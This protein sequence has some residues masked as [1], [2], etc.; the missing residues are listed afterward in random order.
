MAEKKIDPGT[1]AI[2]LGALDNIAREM[3][4]SME[5]SAWSFIINTIRDFSTCIVDSK[6]NLLAV[7]EE[8]LPCQAMSVQRLVRS[9]WNHFKGEVYDGDILM[10]NLAYLGNTHMGEPTVA[11]PVFYKGE[12][13]FFVTARGHMM[14]MGSHDP[15]SNCPYAKDIYY[16]GLKIPPTKLYNRGKLNQEFLDLF[17]TNTRYRAW[18]HG[19]LMAN[20]AAVEVGKE[21]LIK[22]VDQYGPETV[23]FY[24]EEI[25][26]Y[27]E[28]MVREEIRKMKPGTYYAEDWLDTNAYGY[29]N[30]PV[31]AKLTIKD[32]KWIV[33]LSDNV[34]Q[35]LGAVNATLEGCTEAAVAGSLAFSI[36]P[37]IP[38]NEGIH[39][40]IQIICPPGTILSAT[41]PYSTQAATTAAADLLY[42]VL[43]K[44]VAQAYPEGAAA[45]PT[46]CRNMFY[47]G[48]D[49]RGGKDEEWAYLEINRGSGS[50][51]ARDADGWAQ[52]LEF[53]CAGGCRL[54][55]VEMIEWRHPLLI[56]HW[57]IVTDGMGAGKWRGA[58]GVKQVTRC[59]DCSPIVMYTY[60]T[61]HENVPHGVLGGKPGPGGVGYYYDPKEPDKR[62]F[63][64]VLGGVVIPPGWAEAT[65]CSGGG[66]YG[67]P[68]EREVEKVREDVMD[69]FVSIKSAQEDYGV[70]LDPKTYEIDYKATEELRDKIRRER[71][72]LPVF[73]PT[74]P[75]TSTMRQEMMT[76]KDTYIVLDRSPEAI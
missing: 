5:R 76:E 7:P 3:F 35:V 24:C 50:G 4:L 55:S 18:M 57:E 38:K 10:C 49:Y 48:R 23:K 26:N 21:R 52:F 16:E 70:V 42:S 63:Y 69:E 74:E 6:F 40:N 25:L 37:R 13:M 36:D 15:S 28:Q 65:I 71:K 30:I 19:D 54:A 17:L 8:T 53:G 58:P 31:R 33:D 32:D 56:E 60:A 45:G 27:T 34:P 11:A 43:A 59:Y 68:L 46:R 64:S 41:H 66:G 39:R 67:D 47:S 29:E 61:G 14:D 73:S 72:E 1:F 20:V 12:L 75:G 62:I 22:L 44:C 51:G 2:I 9:M